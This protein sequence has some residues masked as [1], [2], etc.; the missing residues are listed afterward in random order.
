MMAL[1]KPGPLVA[2]IRGSVGG[3]TFA[4]NRG[5]MYV[6]NRTTPLNPQSLAQVGVRA[7][8]GLLANTWSAVLTQAQRDAWDDWA[9]QVPV[10][11]AF[12]EDRFLSGINAFVAG[13]SLIQLAGDAIVADAPTVYQKGPTVEGSYTLT[14]ATE[15]ITL[16]SIGGYVPPAAGVTALVFAS[17]PKNPG[18]NFFKG[19]FRFVGSVDLT[20]AGAELPAD[21]GAS[22]FPFAAGQPVFLRLRIVTPDGRVGGSTVGRFLGA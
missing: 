16:D 21:L 11:N 20:T 22:P 4:R 19:P 6:R 8:L 3:A 10:P 5:G 17:A 14:A 1:I 2:D 12:G 15:N 13:N 9:G 18:V 7:T